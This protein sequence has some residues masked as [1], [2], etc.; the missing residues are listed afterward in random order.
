VG[1]CR[2]SCDDPRYMRL[3]TELIDGFKIIDYFDE[4]PFGER[5]DGRQ[6]IIILK[7]TGQADTIAAY[8][9]VAN[10][11]HDGRIQL[12]SNEAPER[13]R[14]FDGLNFP[15]GTAAARPLL[16]RYGL[17]RAMFPQTRR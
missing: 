6:R 14:N 12:Y 17:E 5:D 10:D 2:L 3:L 4:Y 13:S 16:A 11:Q 9:E 15:I 8:L 1:V 7:G